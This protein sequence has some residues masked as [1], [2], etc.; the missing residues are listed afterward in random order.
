MKKGSKELKARELWLDESTMGEVLNDSSIA[1]AV[2][3]TE[4]K[5]QK[6]N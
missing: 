2:E 3:D 6:L 4:T 5:I 1:D